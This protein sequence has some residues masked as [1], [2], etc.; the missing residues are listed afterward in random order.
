MFT[1]IMK[2]V[3]MAILL[4]AVLGRPSA[5]Y[6]LAL[7][8]VICMSAIMVMLQAGFA[9]RFF[10]AAI[11]VAIAVLFNPIAPVVLSSGAALGLNWVCLAA[12]ALSLAVL[13]TQKPRLSI[14]SITDRT[15]G[16][17]SL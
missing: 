12:Y 3:A 9:S 1:N 13:R 11:F 8:L 14:P 16:S 6:E 15:P 5:G 10:L 17:E 2:S 7:R 4:G